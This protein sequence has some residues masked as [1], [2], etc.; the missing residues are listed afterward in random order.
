M[1]NIK[2]W[3][4]LLLATLIGLGLG[5][6]LFG[7]AT[8]EGPT[9]EHDHQEISEETIWTCSMHPQ[10][11][12]SEPGL[13]PICEMELIPLG[14]N[15]SNDPLVLQMSETAVRLADIQ[16][17]PIGTGQASGVRQ[18]TGKIVLD[19]RR[20][21][22]LV[23]HFPGRIEK[24]MVTFTGEQV[25]KGQPL[26]TIYAPELITAQREL[27]EAMK[28][29]N[30]TLEEAARTKL[31][32]WR[33]TDAWIADFEADQT[34]RETITLRAENSGVVA[35]RYVEVGDYLQTGSPLFDLVDLNRLW[36][37]L[38]AYEEDLPFLKM[39]QSITF[40]TPAVPGETFTT[41]ISFIDPLIN[42]QTRTAAVRGEIANRGAKLKP[43][44]LV[45]AHLKTTEMGG[46]ET[47]LIP[48]TAVLWTGER[49]VVYVKQPNELIPSFQFR[50]VEIGATSGGHYQVL[51][52]LE[53]GEEV[54]TNGAFSIDAAAQLNNQRSMMNRMV[55]LG[56]EET[57]DTNL[58]NYKATTPADFRN[59]LDRVTSVY[60]SLKDALVES[61]S[62]S[63][64]SAGKALLQ[65]L[66]SVDMALLSGPAH[67][68]WMDQEKAIRK[69]TEAIVAAQELLKQRTQFSFLSQAVIQ[70]IQAFGGGSSI[71]Y[72]QHC[73][74]A[75]DW[76]GA[77][78]LSYENEIRNPY[79]GD[80]MLTCGNI[81]DSIPQIKEK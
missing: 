13:C 42:A 76:T 14:A 45:R 36:V 20:T 8:S 27:L 1:E 72:V 57:K 4:P 59:Q 73:P 46:Q 15:T 47:L 6:F 35:K 48:K 25:E 44:M 11:R 31:R 30:P 17:T 63:A 34:I 61:D 55:S 21:S 29:A 81:T 9:D 67:H 41:H 22:S 32:R 24:L 19:E 16:T 78:W 54:V 3:L 80:Q 68:F 12:Q 74:M 18:L 10:I 66:Q 40:T 64:Q 51:S 38:D 70:T 58:P 52:G 75:E 5:Y 77:D 23:A 71:V 33:V 37:I 69:H 56:Q 60:I 28:L 49:S 79:F 62:I 2:K 7:A 26:A 53:I 65:A 43:E 50:E 39:G